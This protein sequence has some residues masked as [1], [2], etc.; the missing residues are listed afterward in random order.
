LPNDPSS[1]SAVYNLTGGELWLG[2]VARVYQ[3]P[4]G[5]VAFNLGGG[6]VYPYN[7]GFEIWGNVNPVLTGVNGDT[8][9]LRRGE[10]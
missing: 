9:L 10:L 3:T 2:G 6:R 4:T 8:L 7:A 5:T 1:G